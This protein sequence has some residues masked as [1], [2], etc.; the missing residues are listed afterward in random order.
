MPDWRSTTTLKVS[1][2]EA[3]LAE[4]HAQSKVLQGL[5]QA[6]AATSADGSWN[7][8]MTTIQQ[9]QFQPLS[10]LAPSLTRICSIANSQTP[11]L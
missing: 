8:L 4:V 7:P 1:P 9:A 10:D 6:A 3:A 11:Y 2:A 5:S